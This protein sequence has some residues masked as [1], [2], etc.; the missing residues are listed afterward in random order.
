MK[1]EGKEDTIP[2]NLDDVFKA[3]LRDGRGIP[4]P[5]P[6]YLLLEE[7]ERRRDEAFEKARKGKSKEWL[8][9]YTLNKRK[10]GKSQLGM[11]SGRKRKAL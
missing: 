2:D 1:R 9:T 6:Y 8:E 5:P 10:T 4:R 11:R 7:N 3:L